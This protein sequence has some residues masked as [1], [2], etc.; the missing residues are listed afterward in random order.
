V[1]IDNPKEIAIL[2]FDERVRSLAG[3][4]DP[5]VFRPLPQDDFK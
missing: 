1:N 3:A 5:I 4:I 2:E